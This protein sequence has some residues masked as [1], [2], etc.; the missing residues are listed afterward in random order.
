MR[1]GFKTWHGDAFRGPIGLKK[2][3]GGGAPLI[4]FGFQ[5]AHWTLSIW[6]PSSS[7]ALKAQRAACQL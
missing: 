4:R 7:S 3:G 1:V 6:R 5:F 2:R